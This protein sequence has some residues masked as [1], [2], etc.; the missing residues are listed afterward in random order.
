MTTK[1]L[2][3]DDSRT[4]RNLLRVSLE[5]AGFE[6]YSAC[7]GVE[8]VEMFPDVDPD[9]V[10]TDINMPNMD[11]YGVIE[12]LR[13][14]PDRTSVP[15]VVLTTESSD[16]LKAR[17]RDAGATGWIVKPFDDASL[18]SVLKRLTGHVS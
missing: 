6:F 4:I 12:S 9:V 13:N 18:I 1:V 2:A 17:A 15:I 11:G 10:I 3:I 8:G 5:G 14:G 16:T 7:D